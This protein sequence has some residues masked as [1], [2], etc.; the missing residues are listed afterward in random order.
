MGDEKKRVGTLAARV[1]K[2]LAATNA[3]SL[4]QFFEWLH[5]IVS[6]DR[7]PE[8]HW[9]GSGTAMAAMAFV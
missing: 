3:A 6:S 2:Y 5:V 7:P 9:P 1:L 4:G 8:Q